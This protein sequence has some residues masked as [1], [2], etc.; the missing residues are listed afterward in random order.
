M[1]FDNAQVTEARAFLADSEESLFRA[2]GSDLEGALAMPLDPAALIDRGRRWFTAHVADFQTQVCRNAHVK[3]LV[4]EQGDTA[5][6]VLEIG[7]LISRLVLPVNPVP[8]AVLI[9]RKGLRD[10]CAAYWETPQ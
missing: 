4:L 8:V 2:V 10:F 6:I 1:G 3:D 7:A 5:S 9:V